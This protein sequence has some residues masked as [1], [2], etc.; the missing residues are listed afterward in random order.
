M[1]SMAIDTDRGQVLI[2]RGQP[3]LLVAELSGNHN[4]S[5]QR[6]LELIHAAAESGADAVKLQTYT[7]D[8]ITM[9]A[10]HACF[11]M[12]AGPWA[13]RQLYELYQEAAT[14]WG[15]HADLFAE[16][17]KRG[18]LCF[19]APFDASAVDFLED[20]DC[21]VYKIASFEVI[22]EPLLVRVA[23]CEAPVILSTGMA[24]LAEIARA[25]ELLRSGGCPTLALLACVSAYPAPAGG[26][27][28]RRI[29]VLSQTFNCPAG[30]SDH[31]LTPTASVAAVAQGAQIIEK[32]LTLSRADGGSDAGF[33]LEPEEFA[34]LVQAIR[35]AEAACRE[36]QLFGVAVEEQ[37]MRA[38]RKS[39]FLARD[40]DA[41]ESLMPDDI[42]CVRPADGLPPADLT[43]IVG[44]RLRQPARRGTP[45]SWDLVV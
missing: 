32:H 2:G 30:L 39:L 45:L 17:K 16:A 22:D 31:S 10:D 11:R 28:L 3:A 9:D 15:W 24:T 34:T 40:M 43:K 37:P 33:S 38:Y 4:G 27:R 25:V 44:R 14:P 6:A 18:L 13:G 5:K 41:G 12:A 36:G 42:R 19:S 1:K 29:P 21:P 7:A 26:M 35:D 8:T 23:A 20:L